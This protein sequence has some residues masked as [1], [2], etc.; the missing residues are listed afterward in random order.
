MIFRTMP[1]ENPWKR[2]AIL[3]SMFNSLSAMAFWIVY[4]I[5]G[6]DK[7]LINL[8]LIIIVCFSF[9]LFLIGNI[10]PTIARVKYFVVIM[11]IF[12]VMPMLGLCIAPIFLFIILSNY[13]FLV[14]FAI[15]SIYACMSIYWIFLKISRAI[16][17]AKKFNYLKGEVIE[18]E[19]IAYINR[20]KIKDFSLLRKNT[21]CNWTMRKIIPKIIPLAF[22]GYPLQRFITDIGGNS[23]TFAFMSVLALPLSLYI[24]GRI[25]VGYYLWIYLIGK[26]EEVIGK[27]IYLW[28]ISCAKI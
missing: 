22:L 11:G 4:D 17:I 5:V 20:D 24:M 25:S 23:V 16:E 18:R 3:F 12:S 6:Y 9:L 10:F 7:F 15:I 21:Q 19:K 1:L 14:K 8:F 27:K 28:D 13:S 2:S 26:F